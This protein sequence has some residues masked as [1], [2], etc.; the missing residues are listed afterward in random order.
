MSRASATQ[1]WICGP[2]R[3]GGAV[4][5]NGSNRRCSTSSST[6]LLTATVWSRRSSCSTP[7]GDHGSC[8]SRRSRRGSRRLAAPSATTVAISASS[9]HTTDAATGSSAS[10]TTSDRGPPTPASREDRLL[11]ERDSQLAELAAALAAATAGTTGAIVL[12]SGEAGIGKSSL[13]R[14]SPPACAARPRG[15][16]GG[17]R[18]PAHAAQPRALPRH[19]AMPRPTSPPR[20]RRW[21]AKHY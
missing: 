14:S 9:A 17:V 3:S 12:V 10:S 16:R 5:C 1:R 2:W 4:R 18:R 8:P 7:C 21:I 19:G 11:L 20:S 13:V 15:A 6:S